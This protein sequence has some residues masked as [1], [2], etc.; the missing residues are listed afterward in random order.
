MVARFLARWTDLFPTGLAGGTPALH[1]LAGSCYTGVFL[2]PA[3]FLAKFG[4]LR[5]WTHRDSE[6]IPSR[7][8]SQ[9]LGVS[10]F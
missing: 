2:H 7:V 1:R 5:A 3:V 9:C 8:L 10:V 6:V 4:G